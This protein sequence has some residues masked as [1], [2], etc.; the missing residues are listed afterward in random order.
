MSFPPWASHLLSLVR[1]SQVYE[2]VSMIFGWA[3]KN[4]FQKHL[5]VEDDR[6]SKRRN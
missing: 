6:S 5:E 4:F 1:K 3:G 2:Q